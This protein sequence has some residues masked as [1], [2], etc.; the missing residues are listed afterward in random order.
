MK[1]VISAILFLSCFL[2]MGIASAATGMDVVSGNFSDDLLTYEIEFTDSVNVN[3]INSIR[4]NGLEVSGVIS[5]KNNLTIPSAVIPYGDSVIALSGVKGNSGGVCDENITVKKNPRLTFTDMDDMPISVITSDLTGVKVKA[6]IEGEYEIFIAAYSKDGVAIKVVKG[7]ILEFDSECSAEEC[8]KIKCMAVTSVDELQP[9]TT[10]AEGSIGSGSLYNI[11]DSVDCVLTYTSDTEL[12]VNT[13]IAKNYS[14]TSIDGEKTEVIA[15]YY[16]PMSRQVLLELKANK[17]A[18]NKTYLLAAENVKDKDGNLAKTYM[19][20]YIVPRDNSSYADVKISKT[21][22]IKDFT[23]LLSTVGQTDFEISVRIIN[24][25]VQNVTGYVKVFDGNIYITK[26]PYS[27][28]S[29]GFAEITV[30]NRGY[31]FKNEARI[32]LD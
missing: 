15:A 31:T 11:S 8:T 20:T 3:S 30:I 22:F 5:Q 32:V 23:P 14:V 25:T 12:D 27:I 24:P 6:E 29:D 7:D 19:Q 2:T 28:K 16:Y 13:V 18:M 17:D 21:A 1:R 9:L 10:V 4:I 26:E